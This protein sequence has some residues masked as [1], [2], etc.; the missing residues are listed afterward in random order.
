MRK[1]LWLLALPWPGLASAAAVDFA[2]QIRPIL[3]K[4][5]LACHGNDDKSRKGGLRLDLRDGAFADHDGTRAVVPGKRGDSEAWRRII[6]TDPDDRMPP[7]DTGK[8]LSAQEIALV[9]TWIEEGA[10]WEDHWSFTPVKRPAVPASTWPVKNAVDNFVH[11]KLAREGLRP[12]PQADPVTLA[13]RVS[14]DLTGLPA[15]PEEA[16][17]FARDPSDRAYEALVDRLL[18]TPAYGERWAR[19]WLD[20][21]RYADSKGYEKDKP[22]VMWRYRD[23]VIDAFNRDMPYPQFTLEQIAGDLLPK[24]GPDQILATAFHRNTLTNDEG[25]TDDEEFRVAAVKDRVDT[26]LQTWM[27]LTMGCAKCHE[28]K[29]DPISQKEYYRMYA[30]FNQTA[31]ADLSSDEPRM[32][33]AT[34][35]QRREQERLGQ[36][37]AGLDKQLDTV[38]ARAAKARAQWERQWRSR[39]HKTSAEPSKL[40]PWHTV[41]PFPV[42]AGRS[43]M[44][45]LF[46]PEETPLDFKQ[47]FTGGLRWVERDAVKDGDLAHL[48]EAKR[49]VIFLGRQIKAAGPR[50]L[51][52]TVVSDGTMAVW[53]DGKVVAHAAKTA[54]VTVALAAGEHRLLVK[55]ATGEFLFK[56]DGEELGGEPLEVARALLSKKEKESQKKQDRVVMEHFLRDHHIE[57]RE[58]V[59]ALE[60]AR[61]GKRH[62]EAGFPSIPIMKELAQEKRRPTFLH[63]RGNFLEKG[64]KI[65]PGVPAVFQPLPADAP[66]TRLG[67]ARWLVD[68][69]NPLTARVAANRW[70]A[71]LFGSGIVETEE[72]FGTQGAPPTH[73]EL[74]DWLATTFVDDGWSLKKLAKTIVMSGTYRQ[75]ARVTPELHAKDRFNQWLARGPR[76]RMEAEM[77]R[78][79][80]LAAAGLLSHKVHGPSVMPLQ[81]EGIWSAVYSVERWVTSRGEDGYR[82]GLYT[83]I[84]RSS[85]YPSMITFDAPSREFCS[86]R[87]IR[88]N[89]PLQALVTLND[90]VYIE[91]AQGLARR[92]LKEMDAPARQRIAHGFRLAVARSPS[93]KELQPLL[94]LYAAREA[95][96]RAHAD[97]AKAMA[98]E[99]IGALPD[100]M[101]A[102]EAAAMTAVANVILNLDEFLTKG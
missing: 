40:G 56:V 101:D 25:G 98:T 78:D 96:Y 20:L 19:V 58:Q 83:F 57:G 97:E 30:F 23:W 37:I 64:E 27:G 39:W 17:A 38:A 7:I 59:L 41:G 33:M 90:P 70:W 16:E 86:L 94:E 14:L 85:P 54:S 81:P 75:S 4:N 51:R 36:E 66:P 79:A 3:A 92:M 6:A 55:L 93:E 26:T 28:H 31:D 46:G 34:P 35:E 91:A 47:T 49:G 48:L 18:T 21:A 9:G 62:L 80:A 5:C 84:R 44:T 42:P 22:R 72:D 74:L 12:S 13:R 50:T 67:L 65:E 24:A 95:H 82:R 29:Y 87:R 71:Q 69:R 8:K 10:P 76:F 102:I 60:A 52:F 100:G 32:P 15:T 53:V 73:R 88:S 99:P 61:E 1:L 45:E 43:A 68:P 63:V 77:V 2:Q 11:A 89:T